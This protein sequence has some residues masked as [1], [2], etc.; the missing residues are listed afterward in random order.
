LKR[1]RTRNGSLARR[2]GYLLEC[3]ATTLLLGLVGRLPARWLGP[4]AERLA[5]VLVRLAPVRRKVI[6]D[7]LNVALG[8]SAPDARRALIREIYRHTLL[9]TLECA[10]LSRL[11]AEQVVEAVAC[12]AVARARV[13]AALRSRRGTILAT[14]HFGNWEWGAAW[15]AA[16][17]GRPFGV[18]YKP[19][20]NPWVD[21]LLHRRRE[22]MGMRPFST[23]ERNQRELVA[24]LRGGGNVGMLSDQDARKEGEF[25][26]FFGREAAT[27]T[28]MA[29]LALRLDLNLIMCFCERTGPGQFRMRVFAPT[30][31][32]AGLER[33]EAARRLMLE[34]HRTLEQVIREAP[35]QYFWWHRRWKT[36]PKR[37]QPGVARGTS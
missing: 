36:R 19:L 1:E 18:V 8:S 25:L 22:R 34:Y 20:H 23:R 17:G 29:A 2:A 12:D 26:P 6:E 37:D 16:I 27:A 3:L 15:A 28:G 35:E 32:A 11:T 4:L 9:M 7:N 5:G 14:G 31:P 10:R 33:G 30:M 24:W 21:R 13:E